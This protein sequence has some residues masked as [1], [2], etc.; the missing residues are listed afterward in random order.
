MHLSSLAFI[1]SDSFPLLDEEFDRIDIDSA[2]LPDM[3]A[4]GEP[5]LPKGD[6]AWD[7]QLDDGEEM[8]L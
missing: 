7:D 1:P 8:S 5:A 4:S 3:H 6:R 2:S